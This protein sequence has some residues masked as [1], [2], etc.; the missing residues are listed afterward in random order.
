MSRLAAPRPPKY[1][2]LASMRHY[3]ARLISYHAGEVLRRLACS[4]DDSHPSPVT[5][6][7]YDKGS[8]QGIASDG[9]QRFICYLDDQAM[10]TRYRLVWS[11]LCVSQPLQARL[12]LAYHVDMQ[13]MAE[14]A[15]MAGISAR[16]AAML[17]ARGDDILTR[18][19]ITRA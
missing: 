1:A 3:E 14:V 8:G 11:D 19:A 10:L 9:M 13:S 16:Y 6:T 12:M 15:V 17:V 4:D 2:T 5:A 18:A 7:R